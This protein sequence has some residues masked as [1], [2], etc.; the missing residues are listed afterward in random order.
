ME[1]KYLFSFFKFYK[2]FV[3]KSAFISKSWFFRKTLSFVYNFCATCMGR[4]HI[5]KFVILRF[6][7]RNGAQYVTVSIPY[8]TVFL[9]SVKISW[10]FLILWMFARKLKSKFIIGGAIPFTILYTSV[11]GTWKFFWWIIGSFFSLN[12][13]WNSVLVSFLYV[14]LRPLSCNLLSKLFD[15]L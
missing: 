15:C 14:S 7:Q 9:F 11:M 6:A 2:F 10:K 13:C 5:F 3:I 8:L 4:N 12:I 1:K